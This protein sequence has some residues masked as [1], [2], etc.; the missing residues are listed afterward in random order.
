MSLYLGLD[1]GGTGCRA[2]VADEFAVL[3]RG[4]GGAA[5]SRAVGIVAAWIAEG[6]S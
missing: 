4:A 6:V 3:G 5:N 1:G 2:V